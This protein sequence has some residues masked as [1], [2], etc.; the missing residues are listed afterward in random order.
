MY[1]IL[2]SYKDRIFEILID[3]SEGD[4]TRQEAKEKLKDLYKDIAEEAAVGDISA[5]DLMNLE[6]LYEIVMT[7]IEKSEIE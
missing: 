5:T 3:F 2:K 1:W 7:G 4:L 6:H